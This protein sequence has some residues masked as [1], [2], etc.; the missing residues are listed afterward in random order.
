MLSV[1]SFNQGDQHLGMGYL[2][3]EKTRNGFLGIKNHNLVIP[4]RFPADKK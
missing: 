4:S 1:N 3:E 2:P